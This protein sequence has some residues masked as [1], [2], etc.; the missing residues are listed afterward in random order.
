MRCSPPG[1]SSSPHGN[2]LPLEAA[3]GRVLPLRLGRQPLARPSRS[4]PARRS[5]RRGRRGGPA[6]PSMSDCGPS[7][8][9]Q[10]A[11]STCRHH[12]ACATAAGGREV[13]GQQPAEHERPAEALG[14]GHVAGRL[15]EPR[16]VGVRDRAGVDPERVE[17]APAAPGPRRRPGRRQRPRSPSGTRRRRAAPCAAYGNSSPPAAVGFDPTWVIRVAL[18]PGAWQ[19][20]CCMDST[21]ATTFTAYAR[22]VQRMAADAPELA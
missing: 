19:A 7:G 18:E 13:V 15:D 6:D 14:L 11:P 8:W 1:S 16:E 20:W 4:T 5:S 12:G 22:R 17:R 10:S 21:R 3:A 2:G 9:R